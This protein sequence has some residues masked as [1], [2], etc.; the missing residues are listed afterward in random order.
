MAPSVQQADTGLKE[1]FF[2]YFQHEV[3]GMALN[4]FANEI[5]AL[6]VSQALQEEMKTPNNT[7]ARGESQDAVDHCLASIARLSKR[8]K[9][10]SVYVPVYDQRTYSEV[11]SD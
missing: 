8:I 9:N 4:P 11:L 7:A 3:T 5:G 6:T 10:A 2:R 1:R